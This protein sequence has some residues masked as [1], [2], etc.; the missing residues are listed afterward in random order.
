M[1]S[2]MGMCDLAS[3]RQ[4]TSNP[5]FAR[6]PMSLHAAERPARMPRYV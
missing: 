3:A 2:H 6:A 5:C 4:L 1:R